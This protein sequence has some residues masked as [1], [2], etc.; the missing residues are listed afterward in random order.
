MRRITLLACAAI[1]L[2]ACGSGSGAAERRPT[3]GEPGQAEARS[4]TAGQAGAAAV[5]F[6]PKSEE[7]RRQDSVLRS[8][9]RRPQKGSTDTT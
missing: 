4:G 1:L 9:S 8:G 6:G 7:R 3:A 5:P 2:A